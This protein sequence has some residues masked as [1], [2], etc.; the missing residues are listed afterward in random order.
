MGCAGVSGWKLETNKS[1]ATRLCRR[2]Y[3]RRNGSASHGSDMTDALGSSLCALHG[4]SLQI[5]LL[6]RFERVERRGTQIDPASS[7]QCELRVGVSSESRLP[8]LGTTLSP[9]LSDAVSASFHLRRQES[10]HDRVKGY[11]SLWLST[12]G[13]RSWPCG[14]GPRSPLD[15]ET[16]PASV[17]ES[18]K[19]SSSSHQVV[20]CSISISLAR[21]CFRSRFRFFESQEQIQLTAVFTKVQEVL[22]YDTSDVVF[23]RIGLGAPAVSIPEETCWVCRVPVSRMRLQR[24]MQH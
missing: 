20:P 12:P 1:M 6:D 2:R 3:D 8:H 22:G 7:I 18:R 17:L 10:G 9:S 24:S 14:L 19:A 13:P 23:P 11:V 21:R 16:P 15:A 4:E 5:F